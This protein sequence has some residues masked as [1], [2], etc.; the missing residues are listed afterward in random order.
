MK[1]Q[2]YILN[3]YDG[4]YCNSFTVDAWEGLKCGSDEIR[5]GGNI[6]LKRGFIYF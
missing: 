1:Y 2:N 4:T 3:V 6:G 5:Y